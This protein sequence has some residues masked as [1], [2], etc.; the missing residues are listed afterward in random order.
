M[1]QSSSVAGLFPSHS[2]GNKPT[3][4]RVF[5]FEVAMDESRSTVSLSELACLHYPL[6]YRY[7]FRLS[8]S[9]EEAE[10]L[11]QQTFLIAHRRLEQLRERDSA[12]AWLCAILRNT[13][14]T[15]VSSRRSPRMVPLRAVAEPADEIPPDAV[16]DSDE[17]QQILNEMPEEFRTPLILFYFDE[18]TYREIAEQMHVPI[19]TVMSRLARA[20][21]Y[22][23]RRLETMQSSPA[24]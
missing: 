1:R 3:L 16:V 7:A 8:G 17:L 10:D 19:G 9:A 2:C 5:I 18:F 20:K 12:K 14:L 23:R 13:F 11:T 24:Q 22:L 21:A 6:V 4:E 15:R